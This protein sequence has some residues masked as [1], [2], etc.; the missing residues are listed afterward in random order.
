MRILLTIFISVALIPTAL[1]AQFVSDYKKVADLYF[2]NKEYF[3]AAEYYKKALNITEDSLGLSKPYAFENKSK[4]KTRKKSDDEHIIFKLAESYRLYKD[5]ANAEKWYAVAKEFTDSKYILSHFYYAESLRSNKKFYDAID[6][7]Q[8]FIKVYGKT[9]SYTEKANI[10]IA[11]CKLALKEMRYPRL[12]NLKKL[13]EPINQQGSNYA[14]LKKDSNF[15]FTSSRP[16]NTSGKKYAIGNASVTVKKKETPY[17]NTIYLVQGD[18]MN[19]NDLSKKPTKLEFDI[20]ERENA[21]VGIS[22]NGNTIYF[23]AWNGKGD[24]KTYHIYSASKKDDKWEKPE[25]AGLQVN[26]KGFNAM[27]PHVTSNGKYLIFSSDR[28]GGYG[29][30]DLWYTPIRSD[31]SLG[32][33]VNMGN[34]INTKH[35]EQAAYYNPNT[36]KLLFSSN[37][38]VGLGG[39]DFFESDGDFSNWTEPVNLGFPFNSSKDDIYFTAIDVNGDEGYISSDRESVCC[40]ELFH[41][42]KEYFTIKGTIID[43]ETKGPL[44]G[45]TVSLSDSLNNDKIL[46]DASGEYSFRLNTPRPLK[47]IAE[48]EG[49]FTKTISY[50]YDDLARSDTLL[51]PGICLTPLVINKPI[52]L[53]DIYYEFNS[54]ELNDTSK[55]SLNELVKIMNDNAKITIELSAHTDNIGS[56]EYNMELSQRRAQSCVDYLI[57]EGI[58][59]SRISAKGYGESMPIAPNTIKGKDNPEGRQLNRR[60]EFK[61]VKN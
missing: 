35:D 21:A 45:A 20:P 24:N 51:N 25:S 41:V 15:Y 52:T 18:L 11:S 46:L 26:I 44:K 43:C 14:P 49:Y 36:K 50:S 30:Y 56:D 16:L 27:Q 57:S 7:F 54:A 33:A 58:S 6:A 47:L 1:N 32:Q 40:L 29:K 9:D 2:Q 42:K 55:N 5:F 8:N 12:V 39:F 13:P 22:P 37:G 60:T 19:N 53:S 4:T 3:A 17:L 28:P 59:S 48:K 31:G 34:T 23:T 10:E 38:K 61:V